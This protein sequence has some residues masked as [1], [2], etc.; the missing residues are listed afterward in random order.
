MKIDPQHPTAVLDFLVALML[1]NDI[2]KIDLTV[3]DDDTSGDIYLGESHSAAV[4]TGN[5]QHGSM[6][7]GLDGTVKPHAYLKRSGFG[8][9]VTVS[10]HSHRDATDVEKLADEDR[11][12]TA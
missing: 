11:K 2:E 3:G 6:Y 1:E 5:L 12:A 10:F 7:V 9:T 4:E 8:P